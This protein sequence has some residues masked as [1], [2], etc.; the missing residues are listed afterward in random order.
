MPEPKT[1]I[2][3]VN[4]RTYHLKCMANGAWEIREPMTEREWEEYCAMMV[5]RGWKQTKIT[6]APKNEVST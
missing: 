4:G 6:R 1:K 3:I 2:E 5:K